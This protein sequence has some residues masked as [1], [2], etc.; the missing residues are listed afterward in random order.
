M[1][2]PVS[3]TTARYANAT[4]QKLDNLHVSRFNAIRAGD[5]A[6]AEA[7]M[8]EIEAV[9]QLIADRKAKAAARTAARNEASKDAWY[10]QQMALATIKK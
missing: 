9:R 1:S 5:T 4:E 2:K 7:L 8:V 6:R 3:K 10:R